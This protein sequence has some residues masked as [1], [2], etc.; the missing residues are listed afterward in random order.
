MTSR[1]T[2]VEMNETEVATTAPFVSQEELALLGD[3]EVAYIREM[4]STEAMAAFPN[5]DDL[6]EGLNL[7]ALHGADGQP[8][9]LTDD[10]GVAIEHAISDDLEIATV[11]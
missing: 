4:T 7:F 8:I 10:R 9:A 6:P 2:D 3:G 5:I 11:H 1:K